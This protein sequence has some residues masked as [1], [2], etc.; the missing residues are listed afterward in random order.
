MDKTQYE[1]TLCCK[2]FSTKGNYLQHLQRL[3]PCKT[4]NNEKCKYCNKEFNNKYN[5]VRHENT[6][7]HEQITKSENTIQETI[8][9]EMMEIKETNKILEDKNKKLEEK[10]VEFELMIKN[11]INSLT[12]KI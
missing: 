8:K 6:V 11:G 1:C 7:C 10:L 9:N 12:T 5:R 2:Q 4:N 3:T